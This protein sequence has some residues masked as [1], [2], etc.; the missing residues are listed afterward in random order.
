[1]RPAGTGSI[2][3][4]RCATRASPAIIAGVTRAV[5]A[6]FGVD[7]GPCLCGR[8][9]GRRGHGRDH[10]RDLSRALRRG[11]RPLGARPWRPP[12]TCLRHSRPCAAPRT[13]P[14][15][16][17]GAAPKG[18]AFA[19]S[20]FMARTTRPSIRPTPRRSSPTFAPACPSPAHEARHDGI[21][22]GRAYTCTIVTDARGVPHAECWAIDGLGHA[23]SGGSPEG[24]FTDHHGPDASR[25]MLRFFLAAPAR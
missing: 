8:P 17:E 13:R 22:G 20:S 5:M 24:S 9:F 7:A 1:M 11:R 12:P 16:R 6:E 18:S 19:P 25:E 4:T 15:R 10:G 2:P 14:R 3:H 23:W 21:A